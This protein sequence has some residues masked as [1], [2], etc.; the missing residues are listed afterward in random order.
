MAQPTQ[1][2]GAAPAPAT[3]VL[4]LG[5]TGAALARYLAGRG[6]VARVADTRAE[7]PGLAALPAGFDFVPGPLSVGLLDGIERLL[8]SPGLADDAGVI[9]TAR[10][11]GIEVASDIDLFVA[12]AAAPLL[13]VTGSNGKSTVVSMTAAMLTAAG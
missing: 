13:T 12:A 7:P 11:R 1:R 4:G 3:L 10:R 9:T 6:E 2:N 8:V 5:V